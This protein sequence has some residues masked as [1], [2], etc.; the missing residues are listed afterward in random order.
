LSGAQYPMYEIFMQL[1]RIQKFFQ[2]KP[3][4]VIRN[5]SNWQF[6]FSK[7]L[8]AGDRRILSVQ[9]ESPWF[10]DFSS[11]WYAAMFC[12]MH[13]EQRQLEFMAYLL[14]FGR[15]DLISDRHK[16][17]SFLGWLNDVIQ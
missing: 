14:C 11:C 4:C 8:P 1:K 17:T 2:P 10:L 15:C 7:N 13:A 5:R 16:S 12:S 9:N 3:K 6:E